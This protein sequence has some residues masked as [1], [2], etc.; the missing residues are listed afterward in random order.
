MLVRDRVGIMVLD[1]D[2]RL[3][4][5]R[6]I[7]FHNVEPTSAYICGRARLVQGT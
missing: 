1:I 2:Y 6:S 4:P 3:S 7:P 5:G